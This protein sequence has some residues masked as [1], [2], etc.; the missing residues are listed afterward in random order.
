[1]DGE[2]R[3]EGDEEAGPR[4]AQ[5]VAEIRAGT[6]LDV[7]QDVPESL[8]P[9]SH[10][11]HQYEQAL[12][13]E[14]DVRRLLGDVHRVVDGN[15]HVGRF[16]GRGVVDAVPQVPD[17]VVVPVQGPDHLLLLQ[18]RQAGEHGDLVHLRPELGVA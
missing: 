12:F 3:K 1:M 7:F 6:H 17:D 4:H 10:P 15:P 11:V 9:F 8:P 14:D 16:Q 2:H 18:G 13:Q 5:H